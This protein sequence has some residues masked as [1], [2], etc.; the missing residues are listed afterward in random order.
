MPKI[1]QVP[2]KKMK[3]DPGLPNLL[4]QKEQLS[5]QMEN[6]K[7]IQQQRDGSYSDEI[8]FGEKHKGKT[9]NYNI[10]AK[11]AKKK[12]S[13]YHD[14][15]R[16]GVLKD[17]AENT[18]KVS[19]KAVQINRRQF[20]SMLNKVVDASDIILE[21]IDARDPSGTRCSTL[22]R[23]ALAKGKQVVIVLN[24]IDLVPRD[25]VDGWVTYLNQF[26]PTVAFKAVVSSSAT[27][28]IQYSSPTGPASVE[29]ENDGSITAVQSSAYTTTTSE[30]TSAIRIS[31]GD[32]YGG[33]QLM[34]V[35]KSLSVSSKGH[36]M[37]TTVGV[38]GYPNVGKSSLINSLKRRHA[39]QTSSHAGCTR[40]LQT[41]EIETKLSVIDSPGVVMDWT[42]EAN[43]VL[44][45]AMRVEDVKDPHSAVLSLV[46]RSDINVLLSLYSLD[47]TAFAKVIPPRE[48]GAG[49]S[50]STS[51][52]FSSS[53]SAFPLSDEALS[54]YSPFVEE[55][56]KA[57]AQRHG[58]LL[59]SG[60]PNYDEGARIVLRDWGAGRIPFWTPAPP[61]PPK[62]AVGGTGAA[63]V[64][65]EFAAPFAIEGMGE[66]SGTGKEG[67]EGSEA[68]GGMGGKGDMDVE[69]MD[70]GHSS[71]VAAAIQS[72]VTD[73]SYHMC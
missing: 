39:V 58:K 48:P 16:E 71:G 44:R 1:K 45:A 66:F 46:I 6:H 7:K 3:K 55:F 61:A 43:A 5:R 29:V 68:D 34:R 65:D 64:V 30:I 21:V 14:K 10:I 17:L 25:V 23:S 51:P 49:F 24:K 52:S 19:S 73:P 31:H 59:K 57:V 72:N 2:F 22:E 12:Q 35:C 32:T 42:D 62:A 53:S 11:D 67:D 60:I 33:D 9:L 70:E 13:L 40:G 37:K 56:L 36:A 38:V 28:I 69:E 26:F 18:E 41:V 63:T 47:P 54:R 50:S 15:M 8:H 4:K 20:F 27:G